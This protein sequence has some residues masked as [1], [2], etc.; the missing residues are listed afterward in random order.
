MLDFFNV[1]AGSVDS[2]NRLAFVW[3]PLAK[4]SLT[5]REVI[6]IVEVWIFPRAAW[7]GQP[8]RETLTIRPELASTSIYCQL[9]SH[10]T[11]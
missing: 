7:G 3:G 1:N 4:H 5:D 6:G 9:S 11:F 2:D 10:F 8:L